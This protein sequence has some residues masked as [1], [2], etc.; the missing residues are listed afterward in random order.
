MNV[1]GVEDKKK[2]YNVKKK[3]MKKAN[4]KAKKKK[5]KKRRKFYLIRKAKNMTEVTRTSA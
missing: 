4:K 2:K 5:G 1:V 3:T